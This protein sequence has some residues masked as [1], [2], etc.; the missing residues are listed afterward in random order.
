VRLLGQYFPVHLWT[1]TVHRRGPSVNFA[2]LTRRPCAWR[3]CRRHMAVCMGLHGKLGERS[4]L[5]ALDHA[6]LHMILQKTVSIPITAHNM[7][8]VLLLEAESD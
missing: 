4:W 3:G 2:P 7:L 6:V 8:R 1:F 5:R